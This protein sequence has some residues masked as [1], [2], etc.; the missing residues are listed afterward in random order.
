MD[1]QIDA[2]GVENKREQNKLPALDAGKAEHANADLV[3][4]GGGD[5]EGAQNWC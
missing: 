2:N 5:D 3:G 1:D 4:E